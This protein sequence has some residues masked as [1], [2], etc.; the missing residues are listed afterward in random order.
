M[1]EFV[2]ASPADVK[3]LAAALAEYKKEVEQAGRRVQGALGGAN[4]HDPQK[5]RFEA[6]YKNFSKSINS[7]LNGEVDA[8]IKALNDLA[9]KLTDAKS[10][11]M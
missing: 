1:A 4:W 11:R 5:D 9:A 6:R 10:V 2:H 3:K 7:F 8:M